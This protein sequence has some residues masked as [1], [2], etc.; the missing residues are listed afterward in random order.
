M[1]LHNHSS[2]GLKCRS[3]LS[4]LTEVLLLQDNSHPS[5]PS[6]SPPQRAVHCSINSSGSSSSCSSNRAPASTPQPPY[7]RTT[8]LLSSTS[9]F[10]IHRGARQSPR[11]QQ[12][13]SGVALQLCHLVPIVRTITT[14]S[15]GNDS[16]DGNNDNQPMSTFSAP[17]F[18]FCTDQARYIFRKWAQQQRFAPSTWK[19]KGGW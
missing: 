17:P 18:L 11:L 10:S 15:H 5:P 9:S 2:I 3:P 4:W 7:S 8:S 1:R 12:Q 16:N 19:N 6:P 13:H 14:R